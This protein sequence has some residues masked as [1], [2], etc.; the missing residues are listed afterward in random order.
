MCGL[1]CHPRARLT[2][3]ETASREHKAALT[4]DPAYRPGRPGHI[5]VILVLP[6]PPDSMFILMQRLFRRIVTSNPRL[7]GPRLV[8]PNVTYVQAIKVKRTIHHTSTSVDM[9]DITPIQTKEACP[10]IF[11]P[12]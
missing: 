10:G 11:H 4:L 12:I 6:S 1:S 2:G 3:R 9:A 7:T 5:V 8:V